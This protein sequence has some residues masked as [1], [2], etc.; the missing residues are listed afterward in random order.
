MLEAIRAVE[1]AMERV[2]FGAMP[3][4][5]VGAGVIA[6]KVSVS[7]NIVLLAKPDDDPVTN[8]RGDPTVVRVI[9]RTDPGELTIVSILV[10]IVPF[11]IAIRV[12]REWLTQVF[13]LRLG[14]EKAKG[15]EMRG[16]DAGAGE[17]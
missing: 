2:A 10:A 13:G 5:P 14:L 15:Q 12:I 17:A 4:A 8:V 7:V 3:V 9:R 6:V 16:S 1:N 11:P